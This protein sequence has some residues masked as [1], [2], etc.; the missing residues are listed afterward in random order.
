MKKNVFEKKDWLIL[1][2]ILLIA[3]LLRLYKINSPLADFHSWRQADTAAVARNF[4]KSGFD[5][6]HPRFDDLSSI[7]SGKENPKGYRMV[8]LPIYNVIFAYA[9]KIFP[10]FSLEVFGRLTTLFFSLIIIFVIYCL[11]LMENQRTTAIFTSLVYAILPFIVFFSR[12]VLPETTAVSLAFLGLFFLYLY[13][14]NKQTLPSGFLLVL[15]IVSFAV[16]FLI[17][18]VTVFYLLPAGYL[19]LTKHSWSTYKKV[20]FYLFFVISVTPLLLWRLY[21]KHYPEGIPESSWLLTDVNTYQ[22]RLSIFFKPAFFRLIFFE[23]INNDILGGYLT[24]F[25]ILGIISK[26]KRIFFHLLLVSSIIY[27]FVFQGGNVQHE[28]YQIIILPPLAIFT[29]LGITHFVSSG[30]NLIHPLLSYPLMIVLAV[31]SLFFSFYKVKDYYSYPQDLVQIAKIVNTLT[32]EDDKIV[33]DRL[34]DT[35]LLYLMN[36]RGAPAIYKEP[37]D[38]KKFG[39]QYL[40]TLNQDLI[41]QLK[42]KDY[43]VVFENDSFALFRL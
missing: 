4:V 25:L 2:F 11:S 38:L 15:S 12:V 32:K 21:I 31:F 36:R 9:Y 41:K 23:R 30:K 43:Q 17:K 33:T 8:E 3:T 26:P 40:V 5:F 19:F 1:F 42:E 7:Q 20:S 37:D 39:Y 14:R 22:G 29:G 13:S 6:L 24:F 27:L 28:Y 10:V 34:G 16:S 35:T 18:P